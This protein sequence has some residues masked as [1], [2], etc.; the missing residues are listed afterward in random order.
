M[1]EV[2][3]EAA[4]RRGR[5]WSWRWSSSRRLRTAVN[6][7]LVCLGPILAAV[8]VLAIGRFSAQVSPQVLQL[9]FLADFVYF[10]VVAVLITRRISK[11]M[12]ARRRAVGSKLHLRLSG[13]LAGI[14]LVPT[15]LVAVIAAVTL[16]IG[17]DSWFSERVG[18]VVDSSLAA[19]QAY[20]KQEYDHLV[21]DARFLASYMDRNMARPVGGIE[22][23]LQEILGTGQAQVQR[24]LK[25]A[26]VIN[27]TSELMARGDRSYLFDFEAPSTDDII[28][29]TNGEV[30]VIKDWE[31]NEFRALVKLAGGLDIYLYVSREVDGSLLILLDETTETATQYNQ[32]ESERGRILFELGLV[33]VGFTVLVII[34][35]VWAG[36]WIAERLARPVSRLTTAVQQVAS[37]DLD[38]S[39]PEDRG[40]DEIAVLGR[41]F[42]TMTDRLK[43]QRDDLVAAN[44]RTE[45][46]RRLFDSVLS[47]VTAG[48][49][50]LDAKGRIDVM[51]TA[52]A[53]L[54]GEVPESVIGK[55]LTAVAPEFS[56]LFQAVRRRNHQ[57]GEG[58]VRLSGKG[59]AEILLVR[60]ASRIREGEHLE[61]FVV[62]FDN[63]T[64][65]VT[66]QR[67]AAWGEIAQR[68]AHEVKNPLTPIRLMA[69]RLRNKFRSQLG[70]DA[71]LL[72]Q[73]F[74]VINRQTDSLLRI[75][76]EFSQ[77]ARMP[78]P[79][80]EMHDIGTLVSDTVALERAALPVSEVE[81]KGIS[82]SE[83]FMAAVDPTMISRALI[84]LIKNAGEAITAFEDGDRPEGFVPE[85]R[86]AAER[87]GDEIVITV[88]DNGIGLPDGL[89]S[90]LFEP[91]V[92]HREGGTGL[93]L[94]IV[95]KIADQ[96][97]GTLELEDAP[98]FEGNAHFGA[99]AR[100]T[101]PKKHVSGIRPRTDGD[102]SSGERE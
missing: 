83:P 40:D 21:E 37:G 89:R 8:T 85:I 16:N 70:E 78:E 46:R 19:A 48:V 74:D 60:I 57:V 25:E 22:R 52:A 69:Q 77:F 61:G 81:F 96:H 98:V 49:I 17:V 14:A 87:N 55:D 64:E 26:Y 76:D 95:R 67:M 43:H 42:N 99:L 53:T 59:K 30:V 80:F 5:T 41:S 7:A 13:V 11:L 20:E 79:D 34:G 62:T 54:L 94:W 28:N 2:T 90:R 24:G 36:L 6:I 33:Y 56:E 47:G 35:A 10:A 51:N 88:A 65:L 84:N 92:T 29:A 102:E 73:H 27:S 12:I 58:E 91:Y 3:S 71:H 23:G 45:R 39:V 72:D 75:V 100:L 44:D 68:M 66:A 31:N 63:V 93:G 97:G 86:V 101:L 18:A 1:T 32:L 50:G 82:S 4:N 38:A 9:I 15:V